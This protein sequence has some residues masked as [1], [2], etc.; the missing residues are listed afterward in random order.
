MRVVITGGAG[1]IGMT[2]TRYLSDQG[3]DV[4]AIDKVPEPEIQGARYE[5]CDILDYDGLAR[6]MQ[7]R[8]AVVH[9]AAIPSPRS[10]AGP[11][12]FQVNVSGTYN[13]F[14]AAA[15]AGIRRVVQASS[16]NAFGCA[17]GNQ[18]LRAAYFPI[19]E[20]HPPFT[21][22]VYSFSKQLVEEIG[23]YYWRRAGISGVGLRF[24]WVRWMGAA[25][26]TLTNERLRATDQKLAELAA[27]P[28]RERAAALADAR[29]RALEIRAA[30]GFEYGGAPMPT[31]E[32]ESWLVQSYTVDRFNFWQYMADLDCA[33][34]IE[35]ALLAEYEGSHGLFVHA[36]THWSA[37]ES[38]TLLQM[39]FPTVTERQRPLI[40][41]E[42]LVSSAKARDLIGFTPLYT[43][44]DL[45]G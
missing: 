9:L 35:R 37:L 7:G 22:D 1:R 13:V 28:E 14:E 5:R 19:D 3:W 34:A 26:N 43:T 25:G 32:N 30:G 12:V 21:T 33:R 17:W 45:V 29:R 6:L 27:L 40:G 31:P 20:V 44:D 10:H 36:A 15:Q 42:P 16:I 41:R 23:A 39:F 2:V 24:P 18:D 38:E 11:L 4:L 8:E